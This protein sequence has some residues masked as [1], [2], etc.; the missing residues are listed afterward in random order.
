MVQKY[1]WE[2]IHQKPLYATHRQRRWSAAIVA[3]LR[4]KQRQPVIAE[5]HDQHTGKGMKA[6]AVVKHVNDEPEQ[7]A[8]AH[9]NEWIRFHRQQ[10]EVGQVE[11]TKSCVE[12]DNVLKDQY[13]L[14][15]VNEEWNDLYGVDPVHFRTGV[16]SCSTESC[17]H[18]SPGH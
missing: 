11:K 7:K 2:G 4:G 5:V 13:L 12:Q 18:T 10:Q 9:E 16:T 3:A 17:R 6:Q 8:G 15:K 14:E 1:Q